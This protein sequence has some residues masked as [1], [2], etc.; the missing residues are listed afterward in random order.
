MKKA[1]VCVGGLLAIAMAVY[2]LYVTTNEVFAQVRTK[3]V[4][5]AAPG[6]KV[7]PAKAQ[8]CQKAD[9][10]GWNNASIHPKGEF[11]FESQCKA[12][13]LQAGIMNLP[14]MQVWVINGGM[15]NAPAS[16]AKLTFAS[17][18]PPFGNLSITADIPA[19]AKGAKHLLVVDAP[20]SGGKPQYIFQIAKPV[21]LELDSTKKVDECSETNNVSNYTYR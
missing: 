6:V 12:C 11:P 19:L 5:R 15:T 20:Y 13:W 1:T 3:R 10:K 21:R 14:D 8:L 9:L 7:D 2:G 18:K 17:G 4:E 16:K